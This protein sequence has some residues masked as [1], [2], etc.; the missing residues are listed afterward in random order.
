MT[1]FRPLTLATTLPIILFAILASLN[2]LTHAI[3]LQA[4]GDTGH[5]PYL[6]ANSLLLPRWMLGTALLCTGYRALP[7][8]DPTTYVCLANVVVVALTALILAWHDRGRLRA[9]L[10]LLCPTLLMFASGYDEYYPV[11]V[12]PLLLLLVLIDRPIDSIRPISLGLTLALLA[13]WYIPLAVAAAAVG[14]SYMVQ[15]PRRAILAGAVAMSTYFSLLALFWPGG[16]AAYPAD[17][18]A[19]LYVGDQYTAFTRY[20]GHIAPGSIFFRLDY[21]FTL[22]HLADLGYMGLWSGA[23]LPL[24]L[25]LALLIRWHCPRPRNWLMIALLAQ[26][27]L[28]TVFMAPKLGPRQDIDLFGTTVICQAF[29]IG[30]A[31]DRVMATDPRRERWR[32]RVLVWVAVWGMFGTWMLLVQGIP[33]I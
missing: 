13:A 15:R 14:L 6:V 29:I 30:S 26:Q 4:Y 20:V 5:L 23:S 31:L 17:L 18:Q 11:V 25:P 9:W 32:G 22:E 33:A 8:I 19:A 2:V 21:V 1:R 24:L 27:L 7:G 12:A 16:P 3:V 10:L 28:Y